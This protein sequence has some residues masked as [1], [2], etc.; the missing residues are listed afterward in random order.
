MC[1]T[2]AGN[3]FSAPRSIKSAY[4]EWDGYEQTVLVAQRQY[5]YGKSSSI[6]IFGSGNSGYDCKAGDNK[7]Y[8][9]DTGNGHRNDGER[10]VIENVITID[11]AGNMTAENDVGLNERR[12]VWVMK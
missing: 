7:C 2:G 3:L 10:L 8:T 12:S 1:A 4:K 11:K 6:H 9:Q 5:G